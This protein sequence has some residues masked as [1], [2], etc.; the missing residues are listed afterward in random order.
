MAATPYP[1]PTRLVKDI[2]AIVDNLCNSWHCNL[3][4]ASLWALCLTHW[5]TVHTMSVDNDAKCV[6]KHTGWCP[7][8][9]LV[10][11][12]HSGC[13]AVVLVVAGHVIALAIDTNRGLE[14]ATSA[15]LLLQL[16]LWPLVLDRVSA[17]YVGHS[18]QLSHTLHFLWVVVT[19]LWMLAPQ[20]LH[21][22]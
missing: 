8:S 4:H 15:M 17:Q 6:D 11:V 19:A 21:M 20:A 3:Q 18:M 22:S 16:Q 1:L 2:Y 12:L 14:V 10:L 9:L 5:P 7:V 13:F